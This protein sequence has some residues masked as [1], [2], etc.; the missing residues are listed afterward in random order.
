M[1]SVCHFAFMTEDFCQSRAPLQ[2]SFACPASTFDGSQGNATTLIRDDDYFIPT[3]LRQ[4]QSSLLVWRSLSK[5]AP[6]RPLFTCPVSTLGGSD[7]SKLP[8]SDHENIIP[9]KFHQNR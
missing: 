3:K 6:L 4:N 1:H 5:V 8:V 7:Q 2:L 9:T